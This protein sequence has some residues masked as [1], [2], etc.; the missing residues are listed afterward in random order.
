MIAQSLGKTPTLVRL[1]DTTIGLQ[2]CNRCVTGYTIEDHS[3]TTEA[4]QWACTRKYCPND[5]DQTAIKLLNSVTTF[6]E[7]G[8]DYKLFDANNKQVG[9]LIY[10]TP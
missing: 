10:I 1:T 5:K 8:E 2:G 7:D 9:T 4:D 3:F 6:A